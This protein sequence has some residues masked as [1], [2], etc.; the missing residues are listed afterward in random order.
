MRHFMDEA[1]Q[2]LVAGGLASEADLRGLTDG[3]VAE[4]EGRG[5][6]QLP[7]S[8][9]DFLLRMGRSTGE[10][11]VGTDFLFPKLLQLRAQADELLRESKSSMRLGPQHFVFAAHQ[12][13]QFLY[14]FDRRN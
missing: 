14:F 11:L 7:K 4:L 2:R 10:F 1:V 3:E 6:I 8:Y 12:G 9:R 5:H 13:Y